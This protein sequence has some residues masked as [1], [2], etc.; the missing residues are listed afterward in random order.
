MYPIGTYDRF[1]QK[2]KGREGKNKPRYLGVLFCDIEQQDA[3][4]YIINY[5]EVFNKSSGE[6]FDFYIP[7][8][9]NSTKK[10]EIIFFN[11]GMK[12]MNLIEKYIMNFVINS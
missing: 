7:G 10:V 6:Y 11:L 9:L 12:N 1:I 3:K 2:I 8:Y 4:E 5:M